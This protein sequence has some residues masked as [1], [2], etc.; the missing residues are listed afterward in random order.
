MQRRYAEVFPRFACPEP[1]LNDDHRDTVT[2][3]LHGVDVAQLMM[4]KPPSDPG[5]GG[6]LVQLDLNL[7]GAVGSPAGGTA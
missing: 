2:W 5:S 7:G 4:G 1:A 3:H 6:G